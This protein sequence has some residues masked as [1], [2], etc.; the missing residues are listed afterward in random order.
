MDENVVVIF[1][2][3]IRYGYEKL[4]EGGWNGLD[5][6]R[7]YSRK[8]EYSKFLFDGMNLIYRELGDSN[9]SYKHLER[10]AL[11]P[12]KSSSS[13]N[14]A[15]VLGVIE[16]AK[17]GYIRTAKK[18]LKA[19]NYNYEAYKILFSFE[20]FLME[21]IE[22]KLIEIYGSKWFEKGINKEIL[23]K[24][25]KQEEKLSKYFTSI[26]YDFPLDYLDFPFYYQIIS[27]NLQ[28][29]IKN[30]DSKFLSGINKKLE[31]YFSSI[32]EIRIAIG[33]CVEFSKDE[34][35]RFKINIEAITSFL[36]RFKEVDQKAVA[37]AK[38]TEISDKYLELKQLQILSYMYYSLKLFKKRIY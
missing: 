24:A 34:F 2:K 22:N 30:N 17:N 28:E 15:E 33:H 6:S 35:E 19:D 9:P 11:D 13:Y 26:K 10:I 1:E 38:I 36:E 7:N 25:R 16:A 21:F 32:D 23:N 27:L 14:F 8:E 3:L 12:K 31:N 5:F 4:K 18:P 37:K 29:I 20:N